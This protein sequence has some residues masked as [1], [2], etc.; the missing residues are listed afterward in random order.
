MIIDHLV[1]F[2]ETQTVLHVDLF[3]SK[4]RKI[5]HPPYWPF[6][7]YPLGVV[8]LWDSRAVLHFDHLPFNSTFRQIDHPPHWHWPFINNVVPSETQAALHTD[9]FTCCV[10]PNFLQDD[11]FLEGLR[12][13]L[14]DQIF[15]EKN[16]DLYKFQ[17]VCGCKQVAL[18]QCH[19]WM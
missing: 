4:F 12:D 6:T 16:N 1:L 19:I 7:I 8:V 5:D 14:M 10:L 15:C 3:I 13:E 11:K 9:P 17:Q 2:S 18:R